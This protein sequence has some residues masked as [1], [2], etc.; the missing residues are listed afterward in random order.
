MARKTRIWRQERCHDQLNPRGLPEGDLETSHGGPARGIAG[1][2][3]VLE[4]EEDGRKPHGARVKGGEGRGDEGKS[5]QKGGEEEDEGVRDCPGEEDEA[6]EEGRA[7]G[8][9]QRDAFVQ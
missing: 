3:N 2:G 8:P 4:G 1:V 5:V 7:Q 6:E 9:F